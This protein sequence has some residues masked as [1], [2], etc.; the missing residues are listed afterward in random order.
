MCVLAWLHVYY[1]SLRARVLCVY[2]CML[3][4]SR[5]LCEDIVS[6]FNMYVCRIAVELASLYALAGSCC[7]WRCTGTPKCLS[8]WSG[9]SCP[10]SLLLTARWP[11]PRGRR[12]CAYDIMCLVQW[13]RNELLRLKNPFLLSQSCVRVICVVLVGPFPPCHV[14]L[15]AV[16]LRSAQR[17]C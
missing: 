4:Y 2:I 15:F 5:A 13:M 6:S 14:L 16:R 9:G 12:R 3:S 7:G 11:K 10:L 1:A 8:V 17:P